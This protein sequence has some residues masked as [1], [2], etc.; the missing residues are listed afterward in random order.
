[1]KR[2]PPIR[3]LPMSQP[4][5]KAITRGQLRGQY[6][7]G[8]KV[9]QRWLKDAGITHRHRTLTPKEVLLVEAAVVG[10]KV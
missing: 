9:F 5:P 10:N 3:L 2:L 7:V 8:K 6:N 1:M 4:H